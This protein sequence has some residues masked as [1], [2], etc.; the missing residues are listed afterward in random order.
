VNNPNE[1]RNIDKLILPGV[2]RFDVAM[3][4][5]N[6]IAELVETLNFLAKD[7]KIPILGICLGMQLLTDYSEEG[8]V[9]GLGWINGKTY[10]FPT[11]QNLKIPHMGWNKI[12]R[13]ID[14]PLTSELSYEDRYYFVH[15]YYVKVLDEASR[16]MTTNYGIDFDSGIINK[17]ENIFGLQFHPEKSH[18]FG[19]KIFKNFI[20]I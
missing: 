2:G 20:K 16:M 12:N 11:I 10:K 15:S 5:I 9:S 8:N 4:K 19:V 3:K 13:K 6:E 1:L 18:K 17:E 14:I 7:R